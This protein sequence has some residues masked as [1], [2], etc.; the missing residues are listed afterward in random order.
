ASG[1]LYLAELIEENTQVAKRFGKQLV[2]VVI[3]IHLAFY[4]SEGLPL[5][6]VA[7]GVFSHLVYLTNFNKISWP[8]ISLTSGSFILSCGLVVIDHFAW[9]FYFAERIRSS[10][11]N[12]HSIHYYRAQLS[13]TDS[14]ASRSW[15]RGDG[16]RQGAT[17]LTFWDITT[18]FALCV[19]LVPF[20]LFLSLSASDNV[21]PN[22]VVSPSSS[23]P[24]L[25]AQPPTPTNESQ[26]LTY[27]H[28]Q[29]LNN[30]S[31][32]LLL[33]PVR[34]PG[35]SFLKSILT[36]FLGSLPRVNHSSSGGRTSSRPNEGLISPSVPSSPSFNAPLTHINHPSHSPP[37]SPSF[38]YCNQLS[39][40]SSTTS[41]RRAFSNQNGFDSVTALGQDEHLLSPGPKYRTPLHSQSLPPINT[42]INGYRP[43][44]PLFK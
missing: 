8:S 37:G 40:S 3:L 35:K 15:S 28:H 44:S 16:N 2:Q 43:Q 13:N 24:T 19:W 29:L 25:S 10:A 14:L 21:L 18:F 26:E 6:L 17:Q 23:M 30:S 4:L 22:S 34:Q 9:F 5:P 11:L 32:K 39:P 12:N 36:N 41:P 42:N 31:S 7:L 38:L 1:L 27:D 20:F 33:N